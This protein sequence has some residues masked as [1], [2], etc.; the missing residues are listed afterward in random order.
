MLL[1]SITST[2]KAAA[3]AARIGRV[4]CLLYVRFADESCSA[5]EKVSCLF[6]SRMR[7]LGI[8]RPAMAV[9]ITSLN[10]CPSLHACDIAARSQLGI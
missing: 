2:Q 8:A 10:I 1:I 7:A 5:Q 6:A 3:Q 9:E 4:R